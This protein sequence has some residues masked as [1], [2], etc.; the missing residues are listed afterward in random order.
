MLLDQ[1]GKARLTHRPTCWAFIDGPFRCVIIKGFEA[2]ICTSQRWSR[3]WAPDARG[4]RV[5]H[6][7]ISAAFLV[8]S[9]LW[10]KE[11]V[12]KRN[13]LWV[14]WWHFN[15]GE[16]RWERGSFRNAML[17]YSVTAEQRRITVS[18]KGKQ[19]QHTE[20]LFGVWAKEDHCSHSNR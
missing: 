9:I 4:L 8:V 3:F 7:G 10:Y 18:V 6:A 12:L 19:L 14:I 1:H 2:C 16:R 20:S 11:W 13:T 17:K 15:V 5:V